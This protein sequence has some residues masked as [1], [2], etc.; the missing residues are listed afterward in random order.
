MERKNVFRC[1]DVVNKAVLYL[2]Y[3][4]A[5]GTFDMRGVGRCLHR[6]RE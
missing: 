6:C 1:V 5:D 2:S 3:N 4:A